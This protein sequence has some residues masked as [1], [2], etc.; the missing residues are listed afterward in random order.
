MRP[1]VHR[2]LRRR[3]YS[4]A[5][6]TAAGLAEAKRAQ[7]STVSVVLPALDEEA[8]VGTIV[9]A[10]RADL[11]ERDPLVDEVVV[12]DS[13]SSDRTAAVARA[14]GARVVD[15]GTVLPDHGRVPGKGEALWKALHATSGDL[16]V[17]VDADL[18]G[19]DP[20]Y[21][22]GLVGPLLT[23]PGIGYV[24]ALYDRPLTTTEGIVPS[25][26]GRVT[27]LLARPLLNAFWPELSGFVQPLSGEYAGRRALL[28]RVPFVSGYGVEFGLLVDLAGLAGVDALAQV[29]LGTR[30]HAHQSDAALGRMAGQI[31]QTAMA[32]R[33]GAGLPASELLQFLRTADGVEAVSWD[34]A[35]SERPPMATVRAAASGGR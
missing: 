15:T 32:R 20:Q 2:W 19:F 28:E 35:V 26:G 16:V 12:V 1:D 24:K 23:D 21:V 27:E 10:I 3:T 34:V 11:V 25:G 33:P 4:A 5:S 13:G 8:T 31:L 9:R 14:A 29:D 18:V 17:F 22:V 30:Q 7:G 6:W